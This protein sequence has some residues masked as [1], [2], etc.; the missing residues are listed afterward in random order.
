M[1]DEG[2]MSVI[3][4]QSNDQAARPQ[5]GGAM[6]RVV[7]RRALPRAAKIGAAA[8]ADLLLVALFYW[9]A[10]RANSEAIPADRLTVSTV[11]KGRF[12]DFLPL[13]ARVT[14]LLTVYLDAIEGGRVEKVLVEDGTIVRKGQPL[15][16]LSNAELQLNVLA[17]QSDV[18]R[19]INSMRSLELSLA[20]TKSQDQKSVIEAELAADKARRQYA[21]QKPL[22]EKG[23]IAGKAFRDSRDEFLANKRRAEVMREAQATDLTLQGSQLAQLRQSFA[24]LCQCLS[25]A[26]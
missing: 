7:E 24:S 18:S 17:R 1:L 12:D 2:G 23:F 9:F 20:Q 19:E 22:A 5:S 21:V 13:R 15:A 3:R 25:I 16:I 8:L 4:M 26:L 10:P 11:Q 6:D 14:P